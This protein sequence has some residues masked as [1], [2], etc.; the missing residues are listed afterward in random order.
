MS[1]AMIVQGMW[2]GEWMQAGV[3]FVALL[4]YELLQVSLLLTGEVL[5]RRHIDE[6]RV[7]GPAISFRHTLALL[8]TITAA[9]VLHGIVLIKA[10]LCRTVTWRGV[11]YRLDGKSGIRLLSYAP[12]VQENDN[13]DM[14]L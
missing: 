14:S 3:A 9:Q 8:A 2:A 11:K 1:L 5:V 13:G 12:Y 7:T 10:L 4:G 6:G